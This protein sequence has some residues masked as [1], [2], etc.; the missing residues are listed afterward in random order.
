MVLTIFVAREIR[1][2]GICFGKLGGNVAVLVSLSIFDS[3]RPLC[4]LACPSR[5]LL[6]NAQVRRRAHEAYRHSGRRDLRYHP[7]SASEQLASLAPPVHRHCHRLDHCLELGEMTRQRLQGVDQ[8]QDSLHAL[9][10]PP[11]VTRDQTCWVSLRK[12]LRHKV[13]G[14]Y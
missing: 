1:Q 14:I 8:V 4:A 2:I 7:K 12:R 13:Y 5:G 3:T 6:L 11:W 9:R 10:C